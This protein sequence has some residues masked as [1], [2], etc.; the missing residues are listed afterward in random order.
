MEKDNIFGVVCG[1]FVATMLY[2]F[3]QIFDLIR[4]KRILK[5]PIDLHLI[6]MF[7]L[8]NYL[9]IDIE[10]FEGKMGQNHNDFREC[11]KKNVSESNEDHVNMLFCVCF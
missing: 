1:V 8:M 10:K 3:G 11:R 5:L 4:L 7:R 2:G 6:C 9:P